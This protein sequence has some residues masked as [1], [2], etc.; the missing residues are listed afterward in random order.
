MYAAASE[1]HPLAVRSKVA[2]KTWIA[3]PI[4]VTGQHPRPD[5]IAVVDN[6]VRTARGFALVTVTSGGK[7]AVQPYWYVPLDQKAAT[8]GDGLLAEAAS[9]AGQGRWSDAAAHYAA[10]MKSSESRVR[11]DGARGFVVAE[12]ITS[13]WWW[14]T[15]EY[16]RPIRW[17]YLYPTRVAVALSV[18]FG[19][20]L[21]RAVEPWWRWIVMPR[22]RGRAHVFAP[23]KLTDETKTDLFAAQ[24]SHGTQEV[25][26]VLTWFGVSHVR[27]LVH[28]PDSALA[29]HALDDFSVS[30]SSGRQARQG[31]RVSL[32][33]RTLLWMAC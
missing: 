7:S 4:A 31:G 24:L 32:L 28:A 23:A 14:Q 8:E 3:P 12:S 16:V 15:G 13:S 5:T 20:L 30:G 29:G 17:V 26:E 18:L 33:P 27:R 9:A 6:P 11:A 10:A 19:L 1:T 21:I 2:G 22:F 25:Q